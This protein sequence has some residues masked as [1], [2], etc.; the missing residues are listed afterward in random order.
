M[1]ASKRDRFP[2]M[3]EVTKNA[4]QMAI[5]HLGD[6]FRVSTWVCRRWR[7]TEERD[8]MY[9]PDIGDGVEWEAIELALYG[10]GSLN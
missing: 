3:L 2:W 1:D 8:F 6:A 7:R 10:K 4:P 9:D 5:V